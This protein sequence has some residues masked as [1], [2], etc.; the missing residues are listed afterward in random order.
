M[1]VVVIAVLAVS[2]FYVGRLRLSEIP[3]RAMGHAPTAAG[4][5]EPRTKLV[6]YSVSGPPGARATV[7]YLVPGGGV[8]DE[9]VTLPW[10]TTLTTRD[11]TT[12]A[13][14]LAQIHATGTA[15]CSVRVNGTERAAERAE[16]S[17]PV[18]NCAVPTA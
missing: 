4:V 18:V 10:R 6:E 7:S 16:R 3:D 12:A 13:G 14:V 15:R 9:Q 5:G 11:F 17:Q 1:A 8:A 2:A